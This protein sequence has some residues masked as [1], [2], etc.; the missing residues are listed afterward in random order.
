MVMANSVRGTCVRVEYLVLGPIEN[1]VYIVDD[2]TACFVVDPS[3]QAERILNALDGRK[4]DA[5]VITHGH[6]DHTGAAAAL[7]EATGAPVIV[8]AEDAPLV[9]GEGGPTRHR[10]MVTPCAV[11]RTVAD[12][13]VLEIGAMKWQVIATPGHTP[14]GV[15][16][17]LEPSDGQQGAPVLL[18]GDT[19]FAGTH[20]RTDF[21]ESDP[22]AMAKSLKRLADL[23]EST[24]VLPG[25]NGFTTIARERAWLARG[26]IVR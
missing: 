4:V 12:G 14:G 3:C 13:D 16:Y 26:G 24:I 6:F 25:H 11:D 1:N 8:S 2:G 17:F 18:S 20:G 15:C 21:P 10:N 22:S 19:L 5:I 23:P 9:T 7:R